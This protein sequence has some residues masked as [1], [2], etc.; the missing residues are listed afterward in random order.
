MVDLFAGPGGLGEGFS[1]F[2]TKA[3]DRR[4]F[5]LAVSIE[6]DPLARETLKL[7]AFRRQFDSEPDAYRR[8]RCGE[9]S[10]AAVYE[11]H[12]REA[13]AAEGEAVRLELSGQT[14][15]AASELV[16]ERLRG[17]DRW[18]LIGGPPCQAYSLAGRSRNKGNATYVPDAD[19]R[20]TL[21][22]EYLQI[23]AEHAPPIFVMENVKGLLSARL[24]AET[25][26]DRILTDLSNPSAADSLAGRVERR[27]GPR[28][29][30]VPLITA[31]SDSHDP[32]DFVVRADEHGVPQARHRVI[33]L[34]VR[35]DIRTAVKP[36]RKR[37]VVSV[38][39][40][41]GRF[42]PLRSGVSPQRLDSLEQWRAALRS[43][44]GAEWYRQV[45]DEAV[46]ACIREAIDRAS[47]EDLHRGAEFLRNGRGSFVANHSTRGHIPRDLHRYLFVSSFAE[48]HGRSPVL[49]EFP[50]TLLPDHGNVARALEGGHFEDRFRVQVR[51]RPSTTVT[52]HIA[53]D[54]HYFIHYN[55]AQCRSLTVREAAALQTFPDDYIFCGPRTAQYQ[56][57]GNAVPP[58]LACAI[59]GV[60]HSLL[61]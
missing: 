19:P 23:L 27:H 42:P 10:V 52:S 55:P 8:L 61:E 54:G 53:K 2:Q 37:S 47:A 36:L 38:E 58:K 4:P 16:R 43:A 22:V 9:L 60:V 46:R 40:A 41:I 21:Y 30:V 7:R 28:Y 6:K 51:T 14:A 26:F 24:G 12:P 34:G 56:Q 32:R 45:E 15:R 31:A 17:S 39:T 49:S 13:R 33:L 3:G 44:S 29:R 57:V 20:Q 50:R 18:V 59:A 25:V 5:R 48:I 1:S 11:A 35:D